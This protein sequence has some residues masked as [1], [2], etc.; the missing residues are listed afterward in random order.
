MAHLFW[1]ICSSPI[2]GILYIH[3]QYLHTSGMSR[4]L[5]K[6]GKM[7]GGGCERLVSN[8]LSCASAY[9]QSDTSAVGFTQFAGCQMRLI[10]LPSAGH[11]FF[12][13]ESGRETNAALS[14]FVRLNWPPSSDGTFDTRLI[15]LRRYRCCSLVSPLR[16]DA[17]FTPPKMRVEQQENSRESIIPD[18]LIRRID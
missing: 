11:S 3:I 8:W 15:L 13:S 10:V 18:Y 17:D 6:R 9:G 4:F 2:V 1:L 7:L 16:S 5:A 14:V 12:S